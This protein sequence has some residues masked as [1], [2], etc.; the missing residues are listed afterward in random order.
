MIKYAIPKDEELL[1]LSESFSRKQ[2]VRELIETAPEAHIRKKLSPSSLLR[3]I[4]TTNTIDHD[5]E[6]EIKRNDNLRSLYKTIVEENAA[7]IIP[8]SMAASTV[9]F[10]FQRAFENIRIKLELSRIEPQQVYIVL[11]S[12]NENLGSPRSI[13]ILSKNEHIME[14]LPKPHDGLIQLVSSLDSIL[15]KLIIDPNTQIILLN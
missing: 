8:V 10:P 5:I 1:Q 13:V 9:E 6:Q 4:T 11:E 15:V 7:V 12:T 3:Y 14:I 2:C